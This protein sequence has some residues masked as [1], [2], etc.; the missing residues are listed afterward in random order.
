MPDTYEY[1][2][3][4]DFVVECKSKTVNHVITYYYEW[5]WKDYEG[6]PLD[7]IGN[8][9]ACIAVNPGEVVI[10]VEYKNATSDKSKDDVKITFTVPTSGQEGE[11]STY[12]LRAGSDDPGVRIKWSTPT[13]LSLSAP[14][15][16]TGP[17][18]P[19]YTVDLETDGE[20][21][22]KAGSKESTEISGGGFF[23]VSASSPGKDDKYTINIKNTSTNDLWVWC[24]KWSNTALSQNQTMTSNSITVVGTGANKITVSEKEDNHSG[25]FKCW[26]QQQPQ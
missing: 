13:T 11:G 4:P 26:I 21:I 7:V 19:K 15:S 12:H 6:S 9:V 3:T 20:K 5:K 14:P 8:L 2:S 25:C 23:E 24:T 16:G 1:A 10:G 18:S 17:S 22:W